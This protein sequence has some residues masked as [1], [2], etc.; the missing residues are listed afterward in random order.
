MSKHPHLCYF[1]FCLG[2][3]LLTYLFT[4]LF[5]LCVC[6]SPPHPSHSAFP[7]GPFPTLIH[8]NLFQLEF[9]D[10]PPTGISA[11][12]ANSFLCQAYF[13]LLS[14]YAEQELILPDIISPG[15]IEC[16]LHKDRDFCLLQVPRMCGT[17]Q[18]T[19]N[20]LLLSEEYEMMLEEIAVQLGKH[21]LQMQ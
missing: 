15:A 10:S 16:K 2:T 12:Q 4:Y 17:W 20:F 13:H 11:L 1:I 8:F 18:A 21:L 19:V 9:L 14:I 6:V 7:T 5:L 3:Y